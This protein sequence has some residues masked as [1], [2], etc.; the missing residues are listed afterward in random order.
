MS[1][2]ARIRWP[3][4]IVTGR[5]GAWGKTKRTASDAGR[6]SSG[7]SDSKSWPSAPSPCIQ[8][9]GGVGRAVRG[10]TSTVSRRGAL[11][12]LRLPAPDRLELLVEHLGDARLRQ[13]ADL[14]L[15]RPCRP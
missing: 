13:G 8:D 5:T 12:A 10:S 4:L 9:D 2:H 15:R 11:S 3:P 6:R 7:T 1:Y 14:L